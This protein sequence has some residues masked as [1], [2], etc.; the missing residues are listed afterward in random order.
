M[1]NG[2]ITKINGGVDRL[3]TM[4]TD[5]TY[6]QSI[7]KIEIQMQ[8]FRLFQ[9]VNLRACSHGAFLPRGTD[10]YIIAH[11]NKF[12]QSTLCASEFQLTIA[13][14]CAVCLD[15]TGT[16]EI[17]YYAQCANSCRK[18]APR[19]KTTLCEQAF[20]YTKQVNDTRIYY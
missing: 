9:D 17:W 10:S 19:D 1:I 6:K 7:L 18:F 12:F 8:V 2:I 4:N 5:I 3:I 14:V 13:E 15:V 11:T 16:K 20:T